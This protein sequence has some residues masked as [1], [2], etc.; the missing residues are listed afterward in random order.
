MTGVARCVERMRRDDID[1]LLLGREA[2][3]RAVTDTTR[4]WLAGTRA[5]APG[6]VVVAATGAVHVLSISDDAVPTGFPND[7]LFPITWNP[8][9][10]VAALRAIDGVPQARRIGVDGMTPAMHALLQTAAPDAALV[11]ASSL[12]A[13]LASFD[14]SA[15]A[16]VRAA[17]EVAHAGLAAIR[18]RLRPGVQVRDARAACAPAFARFGVTTPAFDAVVAPLAA[19]ASTWLSPDRAL[20]TG[21]HVVVRVGALRDGWEASLARTFEVDDPSREPADPPDWNRTLDACRPGIPVAV[22]EALGATVVGLGRGVAP[23][24]STAP[25]ADGA[26]L[27]VE[28]AGAA[29]VR[30]DVVQ[31]TAAGV[32]VLTA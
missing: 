5:F 1:V 21:E 4:L 17:A 24:P 18:E 30:Q 2:N 6:C 8:D 14:A 19:G 29:S 23:L 3:A 13:D 16:H 15:A 10:I 26:V 20:E 9:K 25:I 27:S 11:D 31:V 28:V 32:A 22:V 7:R 12:L